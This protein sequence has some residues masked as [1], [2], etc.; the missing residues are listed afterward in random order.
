VRSDLSTNLCQPSP[1]PKPCTLTLRKVSERGTMNPRERHQP[2]H[3][4]RPSHR[5]FRRSGH[6][7]P[8]AAWN[9]LSLQRLVGLVEVVKSL[10]FKAQTHTTPATNLA[11]LASATRLPG[12]GD[13]AHRPIRPI[14][15]RAREGPVTAAPSVPVGL[16]IRSVRVGPRFSAKPWAFLSDLRHSASSARLGRHRSRFSARSFGCD[17]RAECEPVR[18]VWPGRSARSVGVG[19]GVGVKTS[20]FGLGPPPHPRNAERSPRVGNT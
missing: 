10:V 6:G 3:R 7:E 18:S 13:P 11:N 20:G 16:P 17:N 5:G 15:P 4:P 12:R 19:E 2:C 8:R 1:A 9:P 14:S